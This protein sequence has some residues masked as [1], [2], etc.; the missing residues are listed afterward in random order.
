MDE[1][2]AAFLLEKLK[3]LNSINKKKILIAKI[4][5]KYLSS[6]FIKPKIDNFN[7]LI[8]MFKI[9]YYYLSIV[10]LIFKILSSNFFKASKRSLPL[11][12]LNRL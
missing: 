11:R 1:I 10:S 9:F 5:D 3:D 6:K 8:D 7:N 12:R 2:Q 4:Y